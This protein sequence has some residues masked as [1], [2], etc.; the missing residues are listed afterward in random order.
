MM[1]AQLREGLTVAAPEIKLS[2]SVEADEVYVVARHK[3]NSAAV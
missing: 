3:G 2:G 1:T